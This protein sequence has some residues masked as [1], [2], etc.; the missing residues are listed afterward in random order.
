MKQIDYV[1][2]CNKGYI[3]SINQDN[4]L[5]N[6]Q[7]LD[8]NNT[9]LKSP[10]IGSL[11][12]T[13][14][15]VFSVFDGMGGTS[16]GEIAAFISADTLFK[17]DS[18]HSISSVDMLNTAFLEM[19]KNVCKYMEENKISSMGSTSS[20]VLFKNDE[21]IACNLGDSPIFKYANG[22]L[23]KLSS[24]H[25]GKENFL[26]TKPGLTQYIGI[27]EEE[28]VIE[29]YFKTDIFTIGD[30]FLICSDGLTDMV[31]N[32]E[33]GNILAIDDIKTS[34]QKLMEAALE[35]G[36]KDNITIVLCEIN[37]EGI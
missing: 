16:S 28:F 13:N 34:A 26:C 17:F 21:Y 32:F 14:L 24:E 23:V 7:Y 10:L 22:R 4:F 27:P 36:G 29:P 25:V 18:K 20:V 15:P 1:C 37:E 12:V 3:R 6:N 33:I 11:S 31:S 30:R 19:N 2:L 5:V 35:N 8:K 9:G